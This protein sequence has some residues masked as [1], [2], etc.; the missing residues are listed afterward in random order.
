[1]GG[2]KYCEHSFLK[3]NVTYNKIE[4]SQLNRK[5]ENMMTDQELVINNLEKN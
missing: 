1:M 3:I 4:R 2:Y 5:G